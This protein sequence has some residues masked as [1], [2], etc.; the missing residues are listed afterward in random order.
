MKRPPFPKDPNFKMGRPLG[1]TR[2]PSPKR[3]GF[4]ASPA[5][6][7]AVRGKACL[8]CRQQPVEP[9]HV[10]DRSLGGCDHELCTIP[11][12]RACHRSYDEGQLDVLVFLEPH[13]REIQQH[14]VGHL[15]IARAYD[16]L[17]NTRTVQPREAA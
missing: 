5:Q 10:V 6:R 11:L 16:W 8:V 9:C 1:S 7:E 4:A 13:H 15:G 3:N 12:C 14:A 2:K 17:T